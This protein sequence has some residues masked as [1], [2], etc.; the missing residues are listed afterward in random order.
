MKESEL[1]KLVLDWLALHRIFHWRMN[2]GSS[3]PMFYKGKRR[4][5][6]YGVPGV[7][8][9]MCCVKGRMIGI[10]LKGDGGEQSQAQKNF[11]SSLEAAGG[12]Y[13]LARRLDEVTEAIR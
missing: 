12:K 9:I 8:D 7:P 11:Q 10:E 4:F 5:V 13:I 6:R 2:T 3:G 1:L